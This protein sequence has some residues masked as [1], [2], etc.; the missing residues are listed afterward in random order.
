[1]EN[2]V[3]YLEIACLHNPGPAGWGVVVWD[4]KTRKGMSG[5]EAEITHHRM[6]LTAAISTLEEYEFD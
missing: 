4:G 6:Y 1:M 3:I 5:Y 2:V